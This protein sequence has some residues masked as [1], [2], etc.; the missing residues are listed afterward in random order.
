MTSEDLEQLGRLKPL[1]PPFSKV[2]LLSPCAAEKRLFPKAV[3]LT[4]NKWNRELPYNKPFDLIIA[5]NIFMYAQHPEI[6]FKSVLAQCRFF[7]VLGPIR[8]RC[9]TDNEL[10]PDGD[11]FHFTIDGHPTGI[12][13]TFD[14]RRLGD[15]LLGY[16]VYAGGDNPHGS[17]LHVIALIRGEWTD[18]LLRIDDYPTGVRPILDDLTPVHEVLR[19]VDQYPIKFH[20]GIVPNLLNQPMIDFLRS[21]KNLI[22]AVHGFDHGYHQYSSILRHRGDPHNQLGTIRD[23]NEFA[24]QPYESIIQK[25]L[26]AKAI[27]TEA[28]Q[29]PVT[30]Y[31]PPCNEGDRKTGRALNATGYTHY[32]SERP[33]PGC[34]L[35]RIGS[36][37]YGKSS[38]YDFTRCPKVITLHVTWESDQFVQDGISH[39]KHL[40]DHLAERQMNERHQASHLGRSL[41]P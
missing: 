32:L 24:G 40:L 18:P 7:L 23:F 38:A 15:R 4:R 11:G 22:P 9:S 36:D 8:R 29:N 21:L 17:A 33:I 6:W 37:F 30:V 31:I 20:L 16:K 3:V 28:L 26:Q 39:L 25:L 2:A 35:P 12:N 41:F 27:L 14:L 10:G 19:L 13:N 1:L 34:H 5:S